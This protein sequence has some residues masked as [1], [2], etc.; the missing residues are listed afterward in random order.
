[1]QTFLTEIKNIGNSLYMGLDLI[2]IRVCA[3]IL[4][5]RYSS[6]NCG[7]SDFLGSNLIAIGVLFSRFVP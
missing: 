1:M 2:K 3:M 4:Y 6:R 5:V 7:A